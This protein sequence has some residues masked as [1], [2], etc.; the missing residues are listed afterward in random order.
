MLSTDVLIARS[1]VFL[2]SE[3][4]VIVNYTEHLYILD[5]SYASKHAMIQ[6]TS[7]LTLLFYVSLPIMFAIS[8][9]FTFNRLKSYA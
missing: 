3:K 8:F 1:E 9:Q 5:I 6:K 4:V 7:T 2:L